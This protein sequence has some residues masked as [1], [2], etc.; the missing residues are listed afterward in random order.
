V[1]AVARRQTA[2]PPEPDTREVA[3]CKPWLDAELGA[4]A[5]QTLLG[6]DFRVTKQRGEVFDLPPASQIVAT[7]HP[8]SILRAPTD[9]DRAVAYDRFVADLAVVAKELAG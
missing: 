7:V 6:K 2:H 1:D 9:E 4:T 5:A 8:S 3:A